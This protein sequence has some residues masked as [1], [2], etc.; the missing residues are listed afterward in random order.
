MNKL[1]ALLDK[2]EKESRT[3]AVK[4]A[5]DA[6][7]DIVKFNMSLSKVF[8]DRVKELYMLEDNRVHET[9]HCSSEARFQLSRLM[10]KR[11][12]RVLELLGISEVVKD[13]RVQAPFFLYG[14]GKYTY[15]EFIKL[16]IKEVWEHYYAKE[17]DS[18]NI[19]SF[20]CTRNAFL[21]TF[22]T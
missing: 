1:A 2:I 17:K 21:L 10:K 11:R 16:L 9:R 13:E 3:K 22:D 12:K 18:V 4:E 14:K 20:E 15:E 5:L 6:Y 19:Q 8:E 7:S